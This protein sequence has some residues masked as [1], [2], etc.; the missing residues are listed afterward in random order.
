[1][2]FI[3]FRF[4]EVKIWKKNTMNQVQYLSC[5]HSLY[6]NKPYSSP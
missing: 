5:K 3:H 2:E 1:M 4:A 6:L